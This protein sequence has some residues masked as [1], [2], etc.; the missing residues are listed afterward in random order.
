MKYLRNLLVFTVAMIVFSTVSVSAQT[1]VFGKNTE[2]G[3]ERQIF[4]EILKLNYYGVFDAISFKVEGNVVYLSGKVHQPITK[5]EAKRA[6]ESIQ[7]ITDVIDNIEVLPLSGFDDQIRRNIV[8]EFDRRG[9]NI[10]RY[11]QSLNPSMRVI[12]K[13]GHV[14][15]EGYVANQSDANLAR[16]L[17]NSVFGVFSVKNNLMVERGKNL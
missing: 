10:Y 1:P 12:V 2:Q 13:N 16:L 4:K 17:A 6:V 8:R 9:G 11:L 15:L 7:G 5:S 3:I 14:S